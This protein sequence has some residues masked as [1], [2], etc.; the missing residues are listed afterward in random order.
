M[1][2]P[3]HTRIQRGLVIAACL[4]FGIVQLSQAQSTDHDFNPEALDVSWKLVDNAYG[5]SVQYH[6]TLTLTNTGDEPIPAE[7][8]SLYLNNLAGEVQ[9]EQFELIHK[10][11]DL[12]TINPTS[13]FKGLEPGATLELKVTSP[14]LAL[15]VSSSPY[16]LYWVWDS[17]PDDGIS[18]GEY[19]V[20]QVD[21]HEKISLGL[22]ADSPAPMYETVYQ[23]NKQIKSLSADELTKVFPSPVAYEELDQEFQLSADIPIQYNPD[24]SNEA[25]YF[26]KE[27]ENIFGRKSEVKTEPTATPKIHLRKGEEPSGEGYE[28]RVTDDAIT[29]TASQPAGIFYGIQSVKTLLPP[30]AWASEESSLVVPGVEV[31]D[32][33]RF[34]YRSF[35]QDVARNFRTKEQILKTLDLMALYKLNVF[36]FH[37]NDDEGWRIEIPGLPELTEVGSERGH[38]LDNHERLQPSYGSGPDST[39]PGSGYYSTEDFIDILKYATERHIRVIPEIETPGHARAAIKSMD[40]RYRRLMKQGKEQEAKKYLL[41]D[42]GD[43]S[44]YRSVQGWDDNVIN[45][46]LPSTY[47]FLEKVV[48]ELAAM[49]DEAGAPLYRIHMGGDEVPAGV[50]EQSPVVDQLIAGNPDVESTGDL[51]SYFYQKVNALLKERGFALY[52]WEEVGMREALWSGESH[53]VV[54]SAF[55]EQDVQLDVWNNLVGSGD[56]DLAYRLAN[57]GYKV[58]LSGVSNFYFD[59][60]YQKAF[61]EPGLYWGGFQDLEKPFSFIPY[62]FYKNARIDRFGRK[63]NDSYY[64]DMER[65]TDEGRANIVGIQGLLWGEKLISRERQEYMLLPKLLGLAERAWAPQPDWALEADSSTWNSEYNRDWN[66]FVNKVGMRELPRLDHYSGGFEYRIPTAGAT[67]INEEV[68]ANVQMPGF[69]IRYTTDGSEPTINSREYIRPIPSE[70]MIKF[71]VFNRSGRGGRTIKVEL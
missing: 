29:I 49:Y 23:Q 64:Q 27:L 46:A 5:E 14:G 12:F 39:Y 18:I 60:A 4:I 17:K 62:N 31:T 13:A 16:G 51:W 10:N 68:K 43:T 66:R 2:L 8:W 45:V 54:D 55:A 40:A 63:L 28:L 35:M 47:A 36:H 7:G 65:L 50:W 71:R 33:P 37:F 58:V 53:S 56:E 34:G 22:Q 30:S 38:T 24:F 3:N 61:P 57:G 19:T 52:G 42:P 26:S 6:S 41:R 11:G 44:T 69:T 48:D 25:A 15:N 67:V 32:A 9:S 1:R 70:E 21:D 59:L 20:E